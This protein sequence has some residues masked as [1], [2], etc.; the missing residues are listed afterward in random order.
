MVSGWKGGF[1]FKKF[2]NISQT[3]L[4]THQ[5]AGIIE[6]RRQIIKEKVDKITKLQAEVA[7]KQ[8][9]QQTQKKKEAPKTVLFPQKF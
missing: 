4:S 6:R 9:K 1:Y 8:K 7:E 3:F 2:S 5:A